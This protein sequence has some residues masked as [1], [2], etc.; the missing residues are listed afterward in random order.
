MACWIA[1]DNVRPS[2]SVVKS[3]IS[4]TGDV[5][6]TFFPR[7]IAKGRYSSPMHAMKRTPWIEPRLQT[8]SNEVVTA[9]ILFFVLHAAY[10]KLLSTLQTEENFG[11][12]PL[13]VSQKLTVLLLKPFSA[14][15]F[16]TLFLCSNRFSFIYLTVA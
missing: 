7:N 2:T 4:I 16:R 3:I 12:S 15:C 9:T 1:I 14:Y 5:T 8:P 6:R 11:H 10:N 13:L